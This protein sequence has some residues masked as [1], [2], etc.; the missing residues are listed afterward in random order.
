MTKSKTWIN[1]DSNFVKKLNNISYCKQI[2]HQHS[3][4]IVKNFLVCSFIIMQYLVV[5]EGPKN[6]WGRYGHRPLS[7]AAW[8]TTNTIPMCVIL[9]N[10]IALG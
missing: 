9:S 5:V 4:L 7:T 10:F 8:L 2:A 1:C 6:F 3:R